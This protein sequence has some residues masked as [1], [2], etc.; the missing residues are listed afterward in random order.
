MQTCFS[1]AVGG[2]VYGKDTGIAHLIM[3]GVGLII[4]MFQVFILISTQVGEDTTETIIGTDTGGTTSGFLTNDF[5][6]T[7]KAGRIIDIGKGKGPGASRAINLDSNN[8]DR[9]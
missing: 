5:N 6:R 3:T 9:N 7:G 2:G 4:A 8:R 1:G